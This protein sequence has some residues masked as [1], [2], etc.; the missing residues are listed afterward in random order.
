MSKTK[1]EFEELPLKFHE[2][3]DEPDDLGYQYDEWLKEQEQKR[4]Q[5]RKMRNSNNYPT[6]TRD[7]VYKSTSEAD[8]LR[9]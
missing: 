4:K 6:K 9:N 8:R 3:F 1:R 2:E 5:K 7:H